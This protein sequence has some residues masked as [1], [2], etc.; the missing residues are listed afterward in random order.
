MGGGG[1]KGAGSCGGLGGCGVTGWGGGEE[2]SCLM[3]I[4]STRTAVFS[5]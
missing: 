1:G 2:E 5:Q 4:L 3:Q